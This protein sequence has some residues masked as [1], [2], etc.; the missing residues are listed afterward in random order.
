MAASTPICTLCGQP[1][2]IPYSP[3]PANLEGKH[4]FLAGGAGAAAPVGHCRGWLRDLTAEGVEANP[5]PCDGSTGPAVAPQPCRCS[6][7]PFD[8]RKKGIDMLDGKCPKCGHD[9]ADHH[10]EARQAVGSASAGS[11]ALGGPMPSASQGAADPSVIAAAN[12]LWSAIQQV[13]DDE[14][15]FSDPTK[16][17]ELPFPFPGTSTPTERFD[18]HPEEQRPLSTF[19]YMGRSKFAPLLQELPVPLVDRNAHWAAQRDVAASGQAE[20][21]AHTDATSFFP[22]IRDDIFGRSFTTFVYGTIGW[23]KSH[24]L[25]AMVCLL[26]RKGRKVVFLPDCKALL[27][28][29]VDYF[30]SALLLTCAAEPAVQ[31]QVATLCSVEAVVR[32]CKARNDLTFIVDQF[33]AL[34]IDKDK[35]DGEIQKKKAAA[36]QLIDSASYDRA[37]LKA[38][39]ANNVTAREIVHGKQLNMNIVTLFGGMTQDEMTQW[40]HHFHCLE[41]ALDAAA[42]PGAAASSTASPPGTL[43]ATDVLHMRSRLEDITGCIPLYLRCFVRCHAS[44][45]AEVWQ[46]FFAQD[47]HVRR[48]MQHLLG[49]YKEWKEGHTEGAWRSQIGEVRSFLLGGKPLDIHYDHRYLYV[50]E[51]GFGFI[52]CGLARACLVSVLRMLDSDSHF[53]NGAFLSNIKTTRNPS[54]RGFLIEEACL[55]YIRNNG[56]LL[57]GGHGLVKPTEVVYFDSGAEAGARDA[58]SRSP[59]V[60]Y[61]PRPFNYRAVDAVLRRLTFGRNAEGQEV[62]TSVLLVPVQVTV[63]ASHKPSPEAFYPK[64]QVWL[65]DI[66]AGVPRQHVFAWLRRDAQGSISHAEHV[67]GTRAQEII[68]PAYEEVTVTFNTLSGDL[69]VNTSPP[70][71][72]SRALA[73]SSGLSASDTV[74]VPFKVD[75]SMDVDDDTTLSSAAGSGAAA[76]AAA[77]ALSADA[78]SRVASPTPAQAFKKRRQQ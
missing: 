41:V 20:P 38:A 69:H 58:S 52:A 33:N 55:T 8:L 51:K 74:P 19:T 42:T 60:L 16:R 76:A 46:S 45:F 70:T 15:E 72:P 68:T 44:S 31:A 14:K 67:R 7:T 64:H 53:V 22:P 65:E 23:G 49:F 39:S 36:R 40:Y 34:E 24:L 13:P 57:P 61:I 12:A 3:C 26:M 78:D 4:N 5:G 73:S 29:P 50:D 48:V 75:E 28:E 47:V 59:C 54:V 56:L 35:D 63:S 17:M 18:L 66:D 27:R 77:A 62:I 10:E 11:L 71:S 2:Y 37:L 43:S 25:A 32:F 30:R 6:I 1:P 21:A 9:A